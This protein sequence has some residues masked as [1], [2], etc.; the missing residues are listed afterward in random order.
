MDASDSAREAVKSLLEPLERLGQRKAELAIGTL[1]AYLD[2]Q[3]SLS[4]TAAALHLHRNAVA[5][6]ITQIVEHLQVNIADP[7]QRL[8]LQLACRARA[9]RQL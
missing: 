7:D 6:L 5:Y 2:H 4:A 3:G 1:Q 9:L 8:L